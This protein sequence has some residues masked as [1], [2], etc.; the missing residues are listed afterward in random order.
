VCRVETYPIPL[1][2]IPHN[3]KAVK[4]ISHTLENNRY[5]CTVSHTL[6]TIFKNK[7]KDF[8]QRERERERDDQ[9]NKGQDRV[10]V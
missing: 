6:L 7:K 5:M 1:Y 8:S 9:R 2:P 4:A 10:M 3:V